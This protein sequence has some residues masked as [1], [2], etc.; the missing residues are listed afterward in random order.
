MPKIHVSKSVV[1]EKPI[2]VVYDAVRDFRQWPEWSPW[3]ITDPECQVTYADDGK[4]Y[5]WDGKVVGAGEM[6]ICGEEKPS[7]IDYDL[8]FIKP[9]KSRAAVAFAFAQ[10]DG[11][12][13]VSWIMDSSLPFFLFFLK[14]MMTAFV[15]MDYERG[16]TMLKDKLETGTVPSELKFPGDTSMEA[17]DYIGIKRQCTIVDIGPTMEAD[18]KKLKE[19]LTSNPDAKPSCKP[20]SIYHQWNPVKG[21]TEYTI[22]IPLEKALDAAPDG[23][24][25]ATRP[26]CQTFQ[27]EHTGAYRHLGNAWSAGFFRVRNKVISQNRKIHPFETYENDPAETEENDLVT[28]V[29][30]P[31]K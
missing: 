27:I 18:F 10:K 23:F 1:I 25:A 22:G 24:V 19:W 6:T 9:F 14:N 31:L 11:G 28:V 29:H 17:C 21:I 3:L 12:T 8:Q 2:D 4:Q 26:A 20:F 15:G 13:E 30:F 16:L 5:A 7:R